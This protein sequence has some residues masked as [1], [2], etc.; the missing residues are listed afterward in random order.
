METILKLDEVV[1]T[2][3][4]TKICSPVSFK[5][6]RGHR[7]VLNG[8]NGVG[9][10]CL[11]KAILGEHSYF[12]GS[13]ERNSLV[14]VAYVPQLTNLNFF[15]ALSIFDVINLLAPANRDEIVAL[16]LLDRSKLNILWNDASGGERQK[17][18]LLRALLSNAPFLIL[19]EPFN[20]LDKLSIR[21][22]ISILEA[23]KDRSILLI[24]HQQF[25]ILA[26]VINVH[27]WGDE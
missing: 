2:T 4:A 7:I 20:H 27:S 8:A 18:L 5:L 21:R 6:E 19:D 23:K 15:M 14:S 13:I 11:V 24:T 9:K 22:V 26:E 17:A 16:G 25:D 12:E 10:T 1:I 3:P